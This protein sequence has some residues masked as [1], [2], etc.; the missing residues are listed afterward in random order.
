M[1]GMR[2][3]ISPGVVKINFFKDVRHPRSTRFYGAL[4]AATSCPSGE[5]RCRNA[6]QASLAR[7]WEGQ[8]SIAVPTRSKARRLKCD[9]L[10]LASPSSGSRTAV[11][12]GPIAERQADRDPCVRGCNKDRA[13]Q[14]E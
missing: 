1:A 14:S 12:D 13:H 5:P 11:H 4:N 2:F 8:G 7:A 3:G 10:Q 6:K 9:P